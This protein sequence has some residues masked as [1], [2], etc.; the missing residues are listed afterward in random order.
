MCGLVGCVAMSGDVKLESVRGMLKSIQHRG[1]DAMGTTVFSSG[2]HEVFLGHA[3]LSILDLSDSGA[4][5]MNFGRYSIVFN[6]EIYNYKALKMQLLAKGYSFNSG[7]DTEVLL[8]GFHRWGESLFPMLRGMYAFVIFD[9]VHSRLTLVRDRLGVK[10]LYY[11]VID[12]KFFFASELKAILSAAPLS[13]NANSRT[14]SS[15]LARGWNTTT[16]SMVEGVHQVKPAHC[17]VFDVPSFEI[18]EREPYWSPVPL[19]EIQ[20]RPERDL[21]KTIE[22]AIRYRLVSDVEVG[23]FLSGGIDS[24]LVAA[25]AQR[26]S[27]NQLKTYS[28]RFSDADYDEGERARQIAGL[29]RSNHTEYVFNESEVARVIP[30]LIETNDDPFNDWSTLPMIM[31]SEYV[32]RDLKVVLSGDGGDEFFY[33][34][35]KYFIAEEILQ[36]NFFRA[37]ANVLLKITNKLAWKLGLGFL[38]PRIMA[39]IDYR[40]S[41]ST[42]RTAVPLL[43]SMSRH[44]GPNNVAALLSKF[45]LGQINPWTEDDREREL[46]IDIQM[47]LA[48]IRNY[49]GHN[50]LPK[51]DRSTMAYSLEAREPLLDHQVLEAALVSRRGPLPMARPGKRPLRKILKR[52]VP[53]YPFNTEKRGFSVPM[54]HWIRGTLREQIMDLIASDRMRTDAHIKHRACERYV[55]RYMKIERG[56]PKFVWSLF[57]YASWKEKWK[58]A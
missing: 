30:K 37:N 23:C 49:L 19:E 27:E 7:T 47:R 31:L 6:G 4:Q 20:A 56:N 16:E 3:R 17:V 2:N 15:F 39:S 1:P 32:S 9:S 40:A 34:Y 36:S 44:L 29:I 48:D 53:D 35:E 58:V 57:L 25:M 33:G 54:H 10:P 46:P 5:P 52:E 51:V 18:R 42:Q 38:C 12:K 24:S 41:V 21:R 55:Q 26:L 43:D 50:I 8:K 13:L 22:E 45:A 11:G 14:V 28:V